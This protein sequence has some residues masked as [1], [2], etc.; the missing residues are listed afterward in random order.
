[1]HGEI[2][3]GYESILTE[4]AL[5]F[6]SEVHRTFEPRRQELLTARV[7]RQTLVDAGEPLKVAV[8]LNLFFSSRY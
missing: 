8:F 4:E 7:Q 1:M 6:V 3:P 2:K 5:K